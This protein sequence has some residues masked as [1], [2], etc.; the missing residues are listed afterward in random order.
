MSYFVYLLLCNDKSIY[1]GMTTDLKR[2]F[3]EHKSKTGAHYTRVHGAKKM[4][5]TEEHPTRS[6][7]LKREFQIKRWPRRKKLELAK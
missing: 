6:E 4:L 7:A 5:Y 2:R 3:K 1:T